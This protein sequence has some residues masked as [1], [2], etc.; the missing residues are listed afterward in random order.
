L[1]GIRRPIMA[2]LPLGVGGGSA[3]GVLITDRCPMDRA[4]VVDSYA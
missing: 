1:K 4:V 3:T 2:L